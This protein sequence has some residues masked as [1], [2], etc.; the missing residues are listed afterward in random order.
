MQYRE[1]KQL[2]TIDD[3]T[4]SDI[5][6]ETNKDNLVNL[7]ITRFGIVNVR[8]SGEGN[9]GDTFDFVIYGS[10]DK[11]E[12][13]D[14]ITHGTATLGDSGKEYDEGSPTIRFAN[15]IST[16]NAD[17]WLKPIVSIQGYDYNIET[18]EPIANSGIAK[19]QFD[20]MEYKY[21]MCL[22][23][24]GTATSAAAEFT[25]TSYIG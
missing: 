19:L 15:V 20:G 9:Q 6:F 16:P 24:L 25:T 22:I 1:L 18:G 12:P 14:Y 4:P 8:F 7:G 3:S 17:S 10:V 21:L 13:I 5:T 23:K 2:T 11:N